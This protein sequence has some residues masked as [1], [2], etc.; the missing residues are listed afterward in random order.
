MTSHYKHLVWLAVSRGHFRLRRA[1]QRLRSPRRILASAIAVLFFT[2][3]V[4]NGFLV[5]SSRS[6]ADPTSLQLWLSGGMVL[7][8]I[9]H[10]VRCVW[11]EKQADL[12]QTAAEELWLGGAPLHRSTVASYRVV[13]VL[14]SAS[15]KTFF[16]A[17]A[18]APD[19]KQI[20]LLAIGIFVALVLLETVR[21]IWQ[22]FVGGLN[23]Q[24]I[25]QLRLIMTM[26]AT[27]TVIQLFGHLASLTAPGSGPGAY[28]LNSFRALGHVASSHA[29][30]L[31]ALPWRPAAMLQQNSRCTRQC[32]FL[33]RSLWYPQRCLRWFEW[34][35]GLRRV[36]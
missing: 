27:A 10:A 35:I 30:Q 24:R 8:L 28:A 21:M 9:Y 7:Y 36:G 6:S 18:L 3:Y 22:R 2:V 16:L 11:T 25:R 33:P 20:V 12:D 4:L 14:I 31:L 15:L 32:S 1:L 26:I 17:I 29:I 13:S 34:I 23:T 19:A 5:L